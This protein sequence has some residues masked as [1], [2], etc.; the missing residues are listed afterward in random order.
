MPLT[1]H[2]RRRQAARRIPS[3][4]IEAAVDWGREW[5]YDGVVFLRLDRRAVSR[6][7]RSGF[8]LQQFEGVHVILAQDG[9]VLTVYRHRR[10]RKVRR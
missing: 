4:G 7:G 9:A 3:E 2:A 6:A 8:A 10:G 1:A 5:H